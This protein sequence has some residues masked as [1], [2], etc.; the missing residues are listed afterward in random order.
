MSDNT[1]CD[2]VIKEYVVEIVF[3]ENWANAVGPALHYA[4][5]GEKQAGV[6]LILES[7]E[8]WEYW[9]KLETF[10]H[11]YKLPIETWMVVG[12]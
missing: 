8:E 12:Y 9:Y 3:A 1:Q 7:E 11:H 5:L 2:C 4:R 10:I 6:V